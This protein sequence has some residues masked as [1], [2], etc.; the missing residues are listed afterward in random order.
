MKMK[1]ISVAIDEMANKLAKNICERTYFN[2]EDISTAIKVVV[3]SEMKSY[4]D[5]TNN[6]LKDERDLMVAQYNS[7]QTPNWKKVQ[8]QNKLLQNKSEIKKINVL[9]SELRSNNDYNQ[10]KSYLN[11]NGYGY[12]LQEFFKVKTEI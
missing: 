9:C 11:D 12:I 6:D 4:M 1:S 7:A 2:V 10:L 8:L 3:S 5:S